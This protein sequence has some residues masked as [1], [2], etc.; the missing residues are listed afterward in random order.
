ME[1]R[2]EEWQQKEEGP[3]HLLLWNWLC[4][5]EWRKGGEIRMEPVHTEHSF[6][7]VILREKRQHGQ[8]EWAP[9]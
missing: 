8:D 7:F 4:L 5:S 2:R 1:F 3:P 6:G 9:A